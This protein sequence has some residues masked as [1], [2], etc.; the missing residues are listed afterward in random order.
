MYPCQKNGIRVPDVVMDRLSD[1]LAFW[2]VP[3]MVQLYAN[4][5]L[6]LI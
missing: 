1:E 2:E 6:G 3:N 4:R 5:P